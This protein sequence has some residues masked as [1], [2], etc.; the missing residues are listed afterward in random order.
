L[1]QQLRSCSIFLELLFD[2]AFYLNM[3]LTFDFF[4]YACCYSNSSHLEFAEREDMH[5]PLLLAGLEF[6]SRWYYREG[7]HG[8][9][10][11]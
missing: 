4:R 11:D 10:D 5:R 1:D 6:S 3:P 9:Y 7:K 8:G 2:L